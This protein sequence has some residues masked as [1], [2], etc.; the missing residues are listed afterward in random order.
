MSVLIGNRLNRLSSLDG[1]DS[2]DE[3]R[4]KWN[5]SSTRIDELINAYDH[6]AE[7]DGEILKAQ[8]NIN[9]LK[10][11]TEI[12][13]SEEYKAFQIKIGELTTKIAGFN[14]YKTDY[15]KL[16]KQIESLLFTI[17]QLPWTADQGNVS[18]DTLRKTLKNNEQE[19]QAAFTKFGAD[20]N[21]QDYPYQLNKS[22]QELG[23]YLK[24][25]GL[26][27]ENVQ[28]LA[29]ANT[30]IKEFEEQI[31]L[32]RL[33]KTPYDELYAN[34]NK[35]I[36]ASK[37]AYKK[38][39]ARFLKVSSSLQEK[40]AGLSISDKEITFALDIEYS[41]LKTGLSD[42]VKKNLEDDTTLRSDVIERLLFGDEN[43]DTFKSKQTI[44]EYLSRATKA[45]KHR[46]II[47]ELVNND[48]FLEKYHLRMLKYYYS[49]ENI[50]VQTKLAGKLL[51]NTSFG[52]R[53]GVVIAII[54]VAG[55]SPIVIDQPEDHLDGKFISRVLV[56]L[57]RQQKHNRQIILITRDANVVI[58]GDAELIH[59][60]E[61]T[62]SRTEILPSSIEDIDCR[63]KYIWI[64]DGGTNAFTQREQKYGIGLLKTHKES[65]I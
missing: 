24:A 36:E 2:L 9:T 19:L 1:G 28:E 10:K 60:L 57:I 5:T 31:R 15:E 61:P 47:Q 7:I 63:E 39:K 52:E 37:Q 50:H 20:Y 13:K 51:K 25:R 65:F 58:G 17:D 41:R 22:K 18:L 59:I 27:P 23:E 44:R 4:T 62:D 26:S 14:S 6:I 8:E 43:M 48:V 38:Y 40:L 3:L 29:E 53:C 33:E 55:T 16:I 46:Q 54:L 11:Q 32:A 49:I 30:K 56:P 45:Q 21:A 35:S 64:L 34:K 12:I 42:F